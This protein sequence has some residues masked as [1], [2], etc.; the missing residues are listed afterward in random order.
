MDKAIYCSSSQNASSN[1]FS[2]LL[3]QEPKL[4]TGYNQ[5]LALVKKAQGLVVQRTSMLKDEP[6][7]PGIVPNIEGELPATKDAKEFTILCRTFPTSYWSKYVNVCIETST[8]VNPDLTPSFAIWLQ[9]DRLGKTEF[10]LTHNMAKFCTADLQQAV[11]FKTLCVELLDNEYS[12]LRVFLPTTLWRVV[13]DY[14]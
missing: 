4:A 2:P 5:L 12:E 8:L 6:L 11:D 3:G 1:V 14:L 9:V 7:A 10:V 13:R